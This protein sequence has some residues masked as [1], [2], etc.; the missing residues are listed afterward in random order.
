MHLLSSGSGSSRFFFFCDVRV[1]FEAGVEYIF[2]VL[3]VVISAVESGY[4]SGRAFG[5]RG[6]PFLF[7]DDDF[8]VSSRVLTNS[9]VYR[10][11]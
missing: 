7:W 8:N 4:C 3:E 2:Q 10:G 1:H 9:S 5:R 6:M 11:W